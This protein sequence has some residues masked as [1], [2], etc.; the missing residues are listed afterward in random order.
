MVSPR[1]R[2]VQLFYELDTIE[3]GS[4]KLASGR[5]SHYKIHADAVLQ[6][7]KG[8]QLIAE[9]AMAKLPKTPHKLAGVYRGGYDFAKIVGERTGTNPICVDHKQCTISDDVRKNDYVLVLED[10]TTTG[11]SIASCIQ[12]LS[13]FGTTV[14]RAL[15]V[16]DREEDAVENLAVIGV[17]LE[18]LLTKSD[19]DIK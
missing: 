9:L 7:S 19:L 10:V 16:V 8:R 6:H 18:S 11:G 13:S 3:Y 14:D 12:L 1:N 4:I 2:L 17:R 5:I 15:T